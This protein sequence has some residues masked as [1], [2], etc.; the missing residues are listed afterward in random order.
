MT[1]EQVLDKIEKLD[2][3]ISA[4][5]K[6]SNK[7]YNAHKIYTALWDQIRLDQLEIKTLKT[8]Y[9]IKDSIRPCDE[10]LLDF[11][12]SEAKIISA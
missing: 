2:K 9:L 12:R 11:Y 7:Y 4:L 1:K 10:A 8:K 5:I 3:E 6:K